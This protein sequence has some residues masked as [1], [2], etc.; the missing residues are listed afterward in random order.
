MSTEMPPGDNSI[1]ANGIRTNYLEAGS[2]PPVVL[3]HGSGP[4]V[5]A[6]ANWRLTIPALAERF[7][8]LAP[9]MV[10]FGGTERPPGVVYDLKTWAD[11]VVGF[12]DAHGIERASLVGNSFGGAIALRVA[13]Q[14]P[15][16]VG[17]LALMGSAG[18]SFPL[19]DGLDAAWGYQPSIENM[20]RLLDIF[21]YSRELV[22]DELAEVRYRASIEP[23]IQEAFSA[24]FPEP[25]QNGVDALVTP[26]EDLARLPHETLVIHGREDRVV[27][28]SSSIR[29]MEVI[30]KAQLHVFGRSGHWTQ[31]EWA[32]KFNQL[33][34]DF[35]A[36]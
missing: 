14:H 3:I 12:L 20:R 10:G 34:N 30:P 35:L 5:T 2:G 17:R 1:V 8:V 22:T 16:R 6:Y 25:R 31:I 11:Q 9:D 13:T 4:G 32:E 24:M 29:L 36:T 7:R 19:T 23:G 21:A 18:V 27:P 33:L 26:E 15:E 28:L